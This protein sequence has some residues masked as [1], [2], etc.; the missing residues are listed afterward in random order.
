MT[1]NE[2]LG[3]CIPSYIRHHIQNYVRTLNS[4]HLHTKSTQFGNQC[5]RQ[6]FFGQSESLKHLSL[7]AV[8]KKDNKMI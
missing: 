7:I 1:I 5:L 3:I 2:N 4:T 8:M 6:I